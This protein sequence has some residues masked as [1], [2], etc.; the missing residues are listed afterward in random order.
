MVASGLAEATAM[1]PH[2]MAVSQ[3]PDGITV[4]D[5][6]YNANPDS[7]RA[8]LKALAVMAGRQRRSVAV[9]GEMLELG[10]DSRAAHDEIGR[11]VVRLNI[12]LLVVVGDGA[13]GIHDGATQEGRG[14]M[15]H[16]SCPTSRR[17]PRCC[18]TNSCQATWSW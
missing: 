9:L 14:A 2:R 10:P 5:D 13:G 4:I 17:R 3:R 6:S 1:S 8:A 12:K 16:G 11:L 18:A 7:M 15:R